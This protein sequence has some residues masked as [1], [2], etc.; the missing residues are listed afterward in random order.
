MSADA[1]PSPPFY[2]P[3]C[4]K[5][6][7][8][9]LSA[10]GDGSQ[11]QA[12]VTCARCQIVMSIFLGSDGLPKCEARAQPETR[13]DP[14]QQDQ[15][16]RTASPTASSDTA[17]A[18]LGSSDG[19]PMS[20]TPRPLK[21]AG[22]PLQLAAAALVGALVS[23]LVASA[24]TPS[25]TGDGPAPGP[26]A[27]QGAEQGLEQVLRQIGALETRLASSEEALTLE[28]SD[29]TRVERDLRDAI[30]SNAT[31]LNAQGQTVTRMEQLQTS[32]NAAV[33]KIQG[34]YQGLHGRIE[35]NYTQVSALTRR[36]DKLANK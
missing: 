26:G 8:A 31:G 7:R 4:G 15:T 16:A 21:K 29:R 9:D 5:K 30:A 18:A 2:C 19:V 1:P 11:A 3:A 32:S 24:V 17:A 35:R 27:G 22:L 12:R 20:H 25:T 14:A 34:D 28:R 13:S 36:M 23:F 10:L 6:H 33:Q